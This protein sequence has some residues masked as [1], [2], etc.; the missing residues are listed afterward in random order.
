MIRLSVRF[1]NLRREERMPRNPVPTKGEPAGKKSERTAVFL[2]PE[3]IEWLKRNPKGLS[4]AVRA[5]V[6]E[7]MNVDRLRQSVKGIK[8]SRKK[9][10]T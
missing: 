6:L 1:W 10:R 4:A 8:S 2:P 7:A 3:Q 9:S 5:L